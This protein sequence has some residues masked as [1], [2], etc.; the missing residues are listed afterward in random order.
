M[1]TTNS[2]FRIRNSRFA[3]AFLS[4]AAMLLFSTSARAETVNKI[5][6]T[7]D[8]DPV[9]THE[10]Q[11][12]MT[13]R[14]RGA[15]V[16]EGVRP[17]S[18]QV[19]EAFI[20]EKLIQKE[21]SD[22]GIVVTDADVDRYIE[23]I[24]QQNKLSMEQLKQAVEMQGMTWDTYRGQVR[25]ELLKAQLINREIRGKVNVTPEEIQRY[26]EKHKSEFTS[27]AGGQVKVLHILLP[28]PAT[29]NQ[30]QVKEAEQEAEKLRKKIDDP[31]DFEKVAK[32]LGD[33]SGGDLGYLDPESMQEELGAA[34][35]KLKKGKVSEPILTSAGVH[36][37][38]VEDVK[39]GDDDK[40]VDEFSEQIKQKLYSEAMEER[41]DRW[42]REDLRQKHYVDIRP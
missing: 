32:E 6:A 4:A 38:M 11:K 24:R 20:T 28:L 22:Q 18:P 23:G 33:D 26:Y 2:K 29:A 13:E 30:E 25:E 7:V 35:K 14:T 5:L 39:E 3:R 34:V 15:Q 19:L 36:L 1:S 9:T 31:A 16:P 40:P 12:F 8:G 41:Y 42:L 37:V 17:D 27:V 21:I 10:V